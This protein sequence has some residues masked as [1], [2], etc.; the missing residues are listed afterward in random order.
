MVFSWG[1]LIGQEILTSFFIFF[2]S[3]KKHTL[4]SNFD[5]NFLKNYRTLFFRE[6]RTASP[7]GDP[8]LPKLGWEGTPLGIYPGVF[9]SLERHQ[10]IPN[11]VVKQARSDNTE[12]VA[13]WE[14][15]LMP[16]C[17]IYF[18][19]FVIFYKITI[20]LGILRQC[21]FFFF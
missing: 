20:W 3:L 21:F 5:L 15:S 17:K 6:T 9:A 19:L 2:F 1:I 12:G 13:L 7:K 18:L 8:S 14:D 10:P 11:L 4:L 16:G